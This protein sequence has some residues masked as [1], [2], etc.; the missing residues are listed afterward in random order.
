[1]FTDKDDL[2]PSNEYIDYQ[3]QSILYD[4]S[5]KNQ[6]IYRETTRQR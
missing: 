3:Q 1:M 6:Q 4:D 5:Q 2:T